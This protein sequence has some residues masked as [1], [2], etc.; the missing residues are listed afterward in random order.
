ME[1]FSS[2]FFYTKE[3]VKREE[4]KLNSSEERTDYAE[5]NDSGNSSKDEKEENNPSSD[6]GMAADSETE[7][8]IYSHQTKNKGGSDADSSKIYMSE[9]LKYSW[10]K[11]IKMFM[12]KMKKKYIKKEKEDKLNI[13]NDYLS[14]SGNSSSISNSLLNTLPNLS[15]DRKTCN[16]SSISNCTYCKN[17][18]CN[19]NT[20]TTINRNYENFYDDYQNNFTSFQNFSNEQI[21]DNEIMTNNIFCNNFNKINNFP[22]VKNVNKCQKP[23]LNFNFKSNNNYN[24]NFISNYNNYNNNNI[25]Y[26]KSNHSNLLY[27]NRSRSGS[28]Q[29]EEQEE[30]FNLEQSFIQQND[31]NENNYQ[32]TNISSSYNNDYTSNNNNYVFNPNEIFLVPINY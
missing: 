2:C 25:N 18:N 5:S 28:N 20:N 30:N 1:D 15:D 8:I 7:C 14:N 10:K 19:T 6:S 13:D 27:R 22:N 9:I 12:V 31:F 32:E 4:L 29:I 24:F 16:N 11:K 23:S 26:Y 17:N 3:L 21:N